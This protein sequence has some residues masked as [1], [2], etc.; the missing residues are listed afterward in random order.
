MEETKDLQ[1]MKKY[2]APC[3]IL[4]NKESVVLHLEMPGVTKETLDINIDNDLLI[5][6]GKKEK[7]HFK[8]NYLLNEIR[9]GDFHQE[10]TID[11]TIDRN[12]IN[13]VIKNGVVTLT[14]GVKESEKPR[15]IKVLTKE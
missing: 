12:N 7:V 14:L 1:G 11:N 8:G 13:A 4:Q 2:P 6:D 10:Y 5:I 3:D 15:K 9:H